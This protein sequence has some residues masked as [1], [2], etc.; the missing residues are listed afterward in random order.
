MK[1]EGRAPIKIVSYGLINNPFLFI[2]LLLIYLITFYE[3]KSIHGR[4]TAEKRSEIKAGKN[5]PG[6]EDI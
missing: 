3:P 2:S 1:V 5:P 6:K 4:I